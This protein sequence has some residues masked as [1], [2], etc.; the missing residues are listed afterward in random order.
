MLVDLKSPVWIAIALPPDF[1]QHSAESIAAEYETAVD[2]LPRS[3]LH[4][5]LNG[6]YK[7]V[8]PP[9]ALP[10][11]EPTKMAS[12]EGVSIPTILDRHLLFLHNL[13]GE[14]RRVSAVIDDVLLGLDWTN[15]R[16]TQLTA[17]VDPFYF[18]GITQPSQPLTP[19]GVQLLR[20]MVRM[21]TAGLDWQRASSDFEQVLELA[22]QVLR[23]QR[24]PVVQ[25]S[26]VDL[27]DL[28]VQKEAWKSAFLEISL[29]WFG[30]LR[31][32]ASNDFIFWDRKHRQEVRKSRVTGQKDLI[33]SFNGLNLG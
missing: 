20:S 7:Y 16:R 11:P 1:G 3:L 29:D 17:D 27:R 6:K 2:D 9:G 31:G 12:I 25:M 32:A 18:V 33:S 22:G 13:V 10:F 19:M 28:E 14:F 23:G 24:A 15:W 30:L 4:E 21:R 26:Q 8:S 5:V